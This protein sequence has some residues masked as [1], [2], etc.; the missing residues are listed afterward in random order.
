MGEV[1]EVI[2]L[3][4]NPN[5]WLLMTEQNHPAAHP[6]RVDNHLFS[7]YGVT[8]VNMCLTCYPLGLS[9]PSFQKK[10]IVAPAETAF[11]GQSQ[12]CL[13]QPLTIFDPE[14]KEIDG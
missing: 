3:C 5:F 10:N 6:I 14:R 9:I 4:G 12:G 8:C 1:Q 11:S 13:N 2:E 7:I